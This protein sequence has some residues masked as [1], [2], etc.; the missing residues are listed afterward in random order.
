[1]KGAKTLSRARAQNGGHGRLLA[2]AGIVALFA[3]AAPPPARADGNLEFFAGGQA[4]FA[5]FL[6]MGAMAAL[7]GSSIGNGFAVRGIVDAGGYDYVNTTLGTVHANFGGG[8]LDGVYQLNRKTFWIDFALGVNDT[9]TNLVPYDPTNRLA[10]QQTELRA[11]IDGGDISGPWRVDWFGYYG[12]RLDDYEARLGATHALSSHWRLGAEVYAEG[13]PT[14]NLHQAGPYAGWSPIANS[15]LQFSAGEAW[16]SGF[17]P[18]PYLR[19][20]IYQTF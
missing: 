14:Y 11:T 18:R 1:M 12:A 20:L 5:N 10:G 7:P 3:L 13:N 19:A 16:Q 9:Y 6:Y 8:E 2:I 4:D 17:K 15:E